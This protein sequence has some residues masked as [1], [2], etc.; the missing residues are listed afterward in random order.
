M[1]SENAGLEEFV[2]IFP[3]VMFRQRPDF[4]FAFATPPIHDLTGLSASDWLQQPPECFWELLPV[5]DAEELKK[6]IE[7]AARTG[8]TVTSLFRLRH[9]VTHG[10]TC[11]REQRQ[12]LHGPDGALRGFSGIWLEVARPTPVEQ[13]RDDQE[14]TETSVR[15]A[16]FWIHEFSNLMTGVHAIS[17]SIRAQ[18]DPNSPFQE[19]L[20]IAQGNSIRAK[21]IVLRMMDLIAGRSNG[22]R[23]QNLNDLIA[24]ELELMRKILPRRLRIETTLA[25]DALPVFAN[26]VELRHTIIE[27][28]LKIADAM[29]GESVLRLET[30]RRGEAPS[31]R[32]VR[33]K[34][35]RS[36]C[37]CLSVTDTRNVLS[38]SRLAEVLD[39]L[40]TQPLDRTGGLGLYRVTRV[41]EKHRGAVS[42]ESEAGN[43]TTYCIWLPEADFTETDGT[44]DHAPSAA[45]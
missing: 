31:G 30:S 34:L 9:R 41:I 19:G 29:P 37:V 16:H 43:G 32:H 44:V 23:H 27:L 38:E 2:R 22:W 6:Q 45:G 26:A 7:R 10:V 13:R 21:E 12:A 5:T 11:I 1:P 25:P 24:D 36:P 15:L 3:G 8:E 42:V 35:A 17:E 4:S 14:W 18:L 33:G 39:P 40:S 20:E 28:I